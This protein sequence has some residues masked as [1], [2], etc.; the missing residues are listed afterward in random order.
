MATISIKGEALD[1][2][3]NFAISIE[4][5][6]PVFND[7][8][9]QSLPATVP[10][11]PRNCRLTAFPMRLDTAVN[12]SYDMA[13]G[14]VADGAYI[15]SGKINVDSASRTQGITFNLGF[16]NST[17]YQK[18]SKR[19][20]SDLSGLPVLEVNDPDSPDEPPEQL[21][22]HLFGLYQRAD[23]QTDPLAIFPIVVNNESQEE[24]DDNSTK[25]KHYYWELL[26]I[27]G[28]VTFRTPRTV[29]RL[30]DGKPTDIS[31]PDFYGVTP[32]IRVWRMLELIFADA[33]YKIQSNPFKEDIELARLVVLNNVADACC[34]GK[35][36]YSELM[37]DVT[38]ETFLNALWVRFGL[39]YNIDVRT[40]TVS[41][42]LLRDIIS[43]KGL[44]AVDLRMA[45]RPLVTYL[46]PQYVK[47][48]A[49]T[50]F[51]GASTGADRFEDFTRGYNLSNIRIGRD[52]GNWKYLDNTNDWDYDLDQVDFDPETLDPDDPDYVDPN[53]DDDWANGNL[54]GY[55]GADDDYEDRYDGR[56]YYMPR[57]SPSTRSSGSASASADGSAS[58][59]VSPTTTT[60]TPT[61]TTTRRDPYEKQ[62]VLAY[63]TRTGNWFKLDSSNGTTRATSSSFFPWDPDDEELEALELQSDDEW[64]PVAR[65]YDERLNFDQYTPLYLAGSRHYQSY[66]KNNDAAEKAEGTSTPLAFMFALTN[67]S[68][69]RDGTIGRFS[70][71]GASGTPLSFPDG[72][73]HTLSLLFQFRNG[74]FARFWRAYD[75]ILRHGNRQVEAKAYF[76]KLELLRMDVLKPLRLQN[77]PCLIDTASFSLPAGSKVATQLKMRTIMPHGSYNIE[78]EQN[79]PVFYVGGI[80]YKWKFV[81]DNL[82]TVAHS[83]E[84]RAAAF[85]QF[86]DQ[87]P[88]YEPTDDNASIGYASLNSITRVGL[89]W[90]TDPAWRKFAYKG[91]RAIPTYKAKL[92]FTMYEKLTT[93]D[94]QGEEVV[95]K[96][97]VPSGKVEVYV[98]YWVKLAAAVAMK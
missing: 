8:G 45:E 19:R 26:N 4:E 85:A 91:G 35:L 32:F 7:R 31:V 34:L 53:D 13:D 52:V 64:V 43:E 65:V 44:E 12:P 41:L 25:T 37:P 5:T 46:K 69:L 28:G 15:R 33:G 63:E 17:V 40:A 49:Q 20:L 59:T 23:P 22:W 55:Q 2:P 29:R 47:L 98:N 66:V 58:N 61:S 83:D 84:A 62:C 50:S 94:D 67:T 56:D 38:V 16:D 14:S 1:L 21:V 75:E 76:S 10:A 72:S 11:T 6:S 70:G 36:K 80:Y 54:D 27:P 82:D 87:N 81:A 42:R 30:L 96:N 74:L 9:S 77:V 90:E 57:R 48:S 24:G 92:I 18:W 88:D 39:V 89:T 79:I 71:E 73:E 97:P 86:R 51:E 95:G 93:I 78:K 68:E 60:T 3:D